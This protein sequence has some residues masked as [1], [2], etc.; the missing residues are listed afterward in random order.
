MRGAWL[1]LGLFGCSFDGPGDDSQKIEIVD[2]GA[3]LHLRAEGRDEVSASCERT[4]SGDSFGRDYSCADVEL[5][6]ARIVSVVCEPA[7]DCA[8]PILRGRNAY[9]EPFAPSVRVRA[10]AQIGG[11]PFE[12]VEDVVLREPA[13]S[14]IFGSANRTGQVRVGAEL[15]VCTGERPRI[16]DADWGNSRMVV[17][18]DARLHSELLVT[19]ALDA[20]GCVSIPTER[21]GVLQIRL[22]WLRD[23]SLYERAIE[24][25]TEPTP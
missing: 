12:A 10:L 8:A 6:Q 20:P 25:T 1:F 18:V 7:E 16:D 15:T 19:K 5:Q 9:L 21:A 3:R 4:G 13:L 22:L 23:Q 11:V 14:P 2:V 17:R 24:I